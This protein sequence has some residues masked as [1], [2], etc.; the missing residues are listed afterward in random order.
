VSAAGEILTYGGRAPDTQLVWFSRSGERQQVIKAP[1]N[2]YNPSISQDLRYLLAG[3]GTDVWLIDLERDAATRIGAGNSPL[4]SPDGTQ[5]AFTSGRLEGVSDLYLASTVG[6]GEDRLFLRT[7]ENKLVNDWSHDGRYLVFASTNP[8][9]RTDLWVAPTSGGGAPVALLTTSS[10]EFQAQI[11]PDG[12]W[13]AYASDE[14]GR[15]EVYVQSFPVLG[16]KRAISTG[17]GSE[18]Q[19]RRDGRELFYVTAD[20]TLMAVNV[21]S[22]QTLQA[23]RP[24]PLFRTPIPTSGEMN[25]R[26]NHYVA[27]PDGQR[28]LVNAASEAQESISVLVNW[29]SRLRGERPS[30]RFAFWRTD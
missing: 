2:L 29:T 15:W 18:P 13:I 28:F 14:S 25:S 11:S 20:G 10:N 3:S 6:R 21:S 24:M 30:R 9:T 5:I 26:R 27:A 7:G 16:A 8:E 12:R 22:G 19:W 4:I 17:G 23:T 1:P